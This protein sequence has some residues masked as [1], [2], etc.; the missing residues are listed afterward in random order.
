MDLTNVVSVNI[1]FLHLA[2]QCPYSK[3]KTYSLKIEMEKAQ[4][5]SILQT[6]KIYVC[7]F[8]KIVR[9]RGKKM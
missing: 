1:K 2:K 6:S 4:R 8:R 7:K 9:K 5:H 3:V